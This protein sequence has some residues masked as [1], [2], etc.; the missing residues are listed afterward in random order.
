M[1][2][3]SLS[4]AIVSLITVFSGT[5]FADSP[6][7]VPLT[8]KDLSPW[9]GDTGG[10]KIVG[11]AENDEKTQ[12]RLLTSEG[13]GV[14]ASRPG[15]KDA[16]LFS[17]QAFG[18]VGAHFE[19]MVPTKSNSG[20]YFMGRY[21]LQIFDSHGVD[22]KEM[23]FDA[24]GSIYARG[25]RPNKYEGHP[26][27][28]NASKPAGEWQTFDVVFRAPRFDTEG[29]K[30]E[31]AR[32]VKVVHNGVL[33]H[34]NVPVTGPTCGAPFTD[35]AAT[36]PI[37]IQGDHGPIAYR[38][39][40]VEELDA[41]TQEAGSDAPVKIIDVTSRPSGRPAF[42]QHT[43]DGDLNTFWA[44][45]CWR[46]QHWREHHKE[47]W[48]TYHLNRPVSIDRVAVVWGTAKPLDFELWTSRDGTSG[49][50]P[51]RETA[52]GS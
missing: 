22:E 6:G 33:V 24:C 17:K 51:A 37:M 20:I 5:V 34:E 7:R 28:V 1:K 38:D 47:Q 27:R 42:P 36:G 26:P 21:E 11:G 41:A 29:K 8:G 9:N 48:I 10:W 16:N 3:L 50:R 43:L 19:F 52:K 31:N 40:W 45:Q 13:T 39:C 35:E 2:N 25:K 18:D 46:L 4:I 49:K 44:A 32:F 14:L 30:T 23:S 15:G 12:R